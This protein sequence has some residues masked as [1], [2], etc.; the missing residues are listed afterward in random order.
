MAATIQR[1]EVPG[2]AQYSYMISNAGRAV[3]IDP[4]RD[5]DR[6]I[7]YAAEH[8]LTITEIL[9]THIHADFAAG[10]AALAHATGAELALSAYDDGERY[11]YAMPHLRLQDGDAIQLGEVRIE[12]LHTP[13][14]TP[15][16]LSYLLF[17]EASGAAPTAIF[18]GDFLF[19]GALGRPDLLGEEAKVALAHELYRSVQQRI[20]ALPDELKVYPGH[21]AGSLCGSGMGESPE[22]TLGHERT[23]NLF[24]RYSE[25]EFVHEI[26][27]SVPPMPGYYPRMKELNSQGAP[28]L[29]VLP[30][31]EAIPA[32]DVERLSANPD[33]TLLDVR[34]PEAFSEAHIP[35]AINIGSGPSLPLWAGWL[36]R[37]EQRIVLITDSADDEEARRGLIRVGLDSALGYLAGGISAWMVAGLPLATTP[38]AGVAAITHG[39]RRAVLL[40][41]RNDQEVRSG[42]VPGALQIPLGDLPGELD[43]LPKEAEIVTM[44]ASG[45]RA[46]IAASLL[47]HGGF[48]NVSTLRGGLDAWVGVG[49]P[50]TR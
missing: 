28:V 31:G 48:R 24:F 9:E 11:R 10:S 46:S 33:A 18:S 5:I 13:G 23:T 49:Q 43:Q 22:T 40:D 4:I 35:G 30:G 47:E 45:Y 6:Y 44:C 34:S 14:H 26:L 8:K 39:N 15:E 32:V 38:Q 29:K 16:H 20:A 7:Q 42:T 3:V 50:L 36:I 12:A 2:L 37:P 21:G 25:D 1:F 17:D 27:A 41:V 19:V